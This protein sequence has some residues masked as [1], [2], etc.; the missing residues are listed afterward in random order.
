MMDERFQKAKSE[1]EKVMKII[2]NIEKSLENLILIDFDLDGFEYFLSFMMKCFHIIASSQ[3]ISSVAIISRK[4]GKYV[5][6]VNLMQDRIR[7][8]RKVN[9]ITFEVNDDF[10]FFAIGMV[11]MINK[12]ADIEE[13]KIEKLNDRNKHISFLNPIGNNVFLIHGHGKAEVREF[14]ELMEKNFNITPI[15]LSEKPNRGKTIIEQIELYGM[16]SAFAFSIFTPDDWVKRNEDEYFQARPNVLFELGWFCGRYGR[17]K[18]RIIKKKG[19][20]LPSDLGG[21]ITINY[22]ENI[23]EVFL[24]IKEELE[25]FGLV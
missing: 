23:D 22:N 4:N 15:I 7:L 13:R 18:V 5:D 14:K 20:K 19:T 2:E 16:R 3:Y 17:E 24:R 1:L 21:L 11:N 8:Y 10:S 6:E 25:E 9:D 12:M